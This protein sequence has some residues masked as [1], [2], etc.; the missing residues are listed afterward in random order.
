MKRNKFLSLLLCAALVLALAGCNRKPEA[1]TATTQETIV[2]NA[3]ETTAETTEATEPEYVDTSVTY[4]APMSAVSM[5]SVT[6]SSKTSNGTTLFTYTYQNM[7]LFLQEAPIADAI[8]LDYQ[9]QLNKFHTSARDLNAAATT[10]YTGQTDWQPY[11]L[12]VQYQPMR[13]DEMALS[14]LVHETIFEGNARGNSG[15]TSVT[16]DLLTGQALGIRDILV[17]DYSAEDLVELI[18]QGLAQYEDELFPDYAQLVSDM[19]STNRPVENWYFAQDGLC[20]FFNSY[21][22]APYSTGTLVTTIP[23]DA[24]GGLLKDAYFP[25]ESVSFAGTPKVLEFN[26]ANAEDVGNFAEL[27]LNTSGKEYLL[28][29]EGTLLNVRIVSASQHQGGGS[30]LLDGILFAASSISKGDAV[31]IQCD[32]LTDLMVI[33]ESQG[34][35]H[36]CFLSVN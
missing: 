21:E 29:A 26:A 31:L 27:I 35:E 34:S 8:Y 33:Y 20:F 2:E 11:E 6:E 7:T 32:D 16:Y 15:Y 24:L 14:F 9:N 13:F 19:F 36:S 17:A 3:L 18:V 23:Y 1:T 25:A 12:Q 5:P 10:A 4:H 30:I 22:I 28:Y